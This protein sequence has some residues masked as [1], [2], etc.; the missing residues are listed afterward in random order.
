MFKSRLSLKSMAF[1]ACLLSC[2]LAICQDLYVDSTSA[3]EITISSTA[4]S[5]QSIKIEDTTPI[6]I[7]YEKIES[8][9]KNASVP[10]NLPYQNEVANAAQETKLDVALIHAVI[11]VESK[12]NAYARSSKGAYGLMQLMPETTRR[13]GNVKKDNAMQNVLAGSR[14]LSELLAQFGG[15][16]EL[17]LAAYNAGPNA[18]K[19]YQNKIPPYKETMQYVPKVLKYYRRFSA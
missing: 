10:A 8:A 15:N 3:D 11:A 16:L 14:Y 9:A 18:V 13:F 7:A 2:K 4:D 12:H 6:E 5:T 1:V 17:A 19:K